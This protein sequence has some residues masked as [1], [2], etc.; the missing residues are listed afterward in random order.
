MH[1]VTGNDIVR[2]LTESGLLDKEIFSIE[3]END[4]ENG[5]EFVAEGSSRY[6]GDDQMEYIDMELVVDEHGWKLTTDRWVG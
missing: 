6:L 4:N 1:K 2:A 5:A 3:Y